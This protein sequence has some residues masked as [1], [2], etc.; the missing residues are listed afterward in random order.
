MPWGRTAV[1]PA[2]DHRGLL[3]VQARFSDVTGHAPSLIRRC[4][5]GWSERCWRNDTTGEFSQF[6]RLLVLVP[7]L[8]QPSPTREGAVRTPQAITCCYG[9]SLSAIALWGVLSVRRRRRRP[10][11]HGPPGNRGSPTR[12][13]RGARQGG[14]RLPT[15]CPTP[16]SFSAPRRGVDGEGRRRRGP[17]TEAGVRRVLSRGARRIDVP[18]Y[19]GIMTIDSDGT[20]I[21]YRYTSATT[22]DE[23]TLDVR[24]ADQN[25]FKVHVATKD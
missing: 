24:D 13:G 11:T 23:P 10:G 16:L 1:T 9:P 2:H 5:T 19:N 21:G 25:V 17:A 8:G 18:G 20:R 12:P 14:T 22:K 7:S 4:R 3:R 6:P 15:P